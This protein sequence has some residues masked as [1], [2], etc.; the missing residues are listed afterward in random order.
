M[1]A[2]AGAVGRRIRL[3]GVA[4][5]QESLVVDI[6]QEVPQGLDVAVVVGDVRV[7]HVHPVAD[8]LGERLPLL[9]VL[10]H[11]LAAGG[12][13]LADGDLR[14]DIRL[15]DAQFLLHAQF[16]REAVGVPTG[17]PA[18]LETGLGL[19]AAH[20]ILDGTRHHMVDAGHAVGRRRT[21]EEDE[22]RSALPE[23]QGLLESPACKP[24]FED[25]IPGRDQIKALVF[26]ESHIFCLILY[27][28]FRMQR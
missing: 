22:F 21:L 4:L 23:L 12:V 19:V 2:Q 14:A 20:G 7:F 24:S 13:V 27:A 8:A 25:C 5:V 9:R 6:L 18:D 17:A 16:H 15:G 26:F 3:D 11:L 1:G 28:Q 10:H